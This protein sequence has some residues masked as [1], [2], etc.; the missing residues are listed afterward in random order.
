MANC[1]QCSAPLP[2]NSNVC[3]YCG[4]RNDV[5]LRA[6]QPYS[7]TSGVSERICPHCDIALQTIRLNFEEAFFIE[8]C[9]SCFG[10]FFDRGEIEAML[11]HSVSQVYDIN[12]LHIDNINKDRYRANQK[13][14][15]LKCPECRILMNRINFGYRSGVVVDQCKIHGIWLDS[16]ELIHLLEWKKA[17]GQLL[18]QKTAGLRQ[19]PKKP[20]VPLPYSDDNNLG[21]KG[22]F[23][24]GPETG[25]AETVVSL[26]FK[27]FE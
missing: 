24:S 23:G 14:Q 2:A 25:L 5:D 1:T 15:Y 10:F 27:L 11:H 17:G 26:I 7:V 20:Y 3:L 19:Q 4:T 16:G 6:K 21:S 13:V 18:Q 22:S 8:R 12:P 9:A